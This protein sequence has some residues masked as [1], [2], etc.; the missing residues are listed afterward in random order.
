MRYNS[1]VSTGATLIIDIDSSSVGACV[2][3]E[4]N[5]EPVVSNV[6]RV[7]VGTGAVRDANAL[8]PQLKEALG[9]LLADYKSLNP[10]NVFVVTA[11]PWFTASL[12][13]LAS[14]SEKPVKV[15]QSTV[16]RVVSDYR[17]TEHPAGHVLESL[18][19]SVTVNGYRTRVLKPLL[20]S[21][22]GVTLYESAIDEGCA[23]TVTEAIAG[24]APHARLVWHSTPIV[25]AEMVTSLLGAEYV[26]VVDVGGEQTDLMIISRGSIGFVGSLPEGA[27]SVA[28]TVATA[29]AG[30]GEGSLPDALSR[31]NMLAS[32]ELAEADTQA[33]AAALTNAGTSWSKNFMEV[34]VGVSNTVPVPHRVVAIGEGDDMSW[35]SRVIRGAGDAPAAAIHVGEPE[36]VGPEFFKGGLSFGEGGAY[37]ASLALSAL[38]F[39]T[40]HRTTAAGPDYPPVLYSVH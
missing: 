28:R 9:T 39:H 16:A 22:L 6:K 34:L 25:Y 12:R 29:L 2:L 37:D 8:V 23:R 11:S 26:T 17:K 21:T 38:F 32:S 33:T 35:F 18:P 13:T 19:I 31:L 5:H 14:K 7:P 30:K 15:S 4:I 36:V 27:R 1:N 24:V 3:T 10:K 20:G 40:R